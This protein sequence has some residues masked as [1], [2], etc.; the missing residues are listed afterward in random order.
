[1]NK[2]FVTGEH[3]RTLWPLSTN[4]GEQFPKG[5][6]FTVGSCGLFL[7]ADDGR[8]MMTYGLLM[9]EQ[10]FERLTDETTTD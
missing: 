6:V 1:M 9:C 10:N 2:G 5:T 4:A 7:T 8:T 3:I